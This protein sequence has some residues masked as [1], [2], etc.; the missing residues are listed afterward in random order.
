[1]HHDD[2]ACGGGGADANANAPVDGGVDAINVQDMD[3]GSYEVTYVAS[4]AGVYELSVLC[5]GAHAADSPYPVRVLPG[6]AVFAR[7]LVTGVQSAVRPGETMEF[8][9]QAR[10]R[11]GNRCTSDPDTDGPLEVLLDGSGDAVRVAR[12]GDG[13]IIVRIAIDEECGD[14]PSAAGSL[15][16]PN[17]CSITAG[18]TSHSDGRAPPLAPSSKGRKVLRV[19]LG[20]RDVPGTPFSI[21]CGDC[22]GDCAGDRCGDRCGDCG[23][24]GRDGHGD[25]GG[26][27]GGGRSPR[28]NRARQC[29]ELGPQQR[30]VERSK[31][32]AF[33]FEDDDGWDSGTDEGDGEAAGGDKVP[34]VEN[35]EDLWLVSKLQQERKAKEAKEKKSRVEAMRR[36]LEASFEKDSEDPEDKAAD[37]R[38]FLGG[39]DDFGRGDDERGD[40]ERGDDE[41]GD[42]GRGDDER[43]DDERGDGAGAAS[44]GASSERVVVGGGRARSLAR[45][46]RALDDV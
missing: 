46:A 41:R 12:A 4:V 20:G 43:G 6:P 30:G 19:L 5:R 39:M 25:G 28:D 34:V 40:D 21:E 10:D 44:D 2:G 7:T 24:G 32:D 14:E 23:G 17:A 27:D 35:L 16:D 13:R 8:E 29:A 33:V 1:V 9:I 18:K 15:V 22:A 3:D 31:W 37:F 45:A 38:A 42:D 26:S 11:F 36:T